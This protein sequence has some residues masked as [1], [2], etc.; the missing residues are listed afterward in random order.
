MTPWLSASTATHDEL[1]SKSARC[2]AGTS[3]FI[4]ESQAGRKPEA[5]SRK[6]EA[7]R[8]RV[9]GTRTPRK[10]DS[11]KKTHQW[12]RIL[13]IHCMRGVRPCYGSRCATVAAVVEV[14]IS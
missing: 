12:V 7:I 11:S 8:G 2:G 4:K 3:N 13:E 9:K 6:S 1:V 14:G 10:D 5:G